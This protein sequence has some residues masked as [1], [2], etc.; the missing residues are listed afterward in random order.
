MTPEWLRMSAGDLGRG[1]ERGEIDPVRLTMAHLDALEAHPLTPRVFSRLTPDRAL[2]EA[3]AASNRAKAGCRRGPLDGIPVSWKDLFDT[4]A[5]ATEA[6]S[7]LLAGRVPERD[8]AVLRNAAA[9]GIVCLGKTHMSELAFS[10]LGY[11][12]VTATPPSVNDAE[13]VAGGSSSGAAAS[14]AFGLSVCGIGSDTGG[15]VRIPSAWNDLVG[16]KTTVGRLPLEGVVPLCPG[17]D[18]VG[19]LCRSVEDAALMLAALEGTV[20]PDLAGASLRGVRLMALETVAMSDLRPE[21]RTGFDLAVALLRDAGATVRPVEV[22]AVAEAMEL[23]SILFTS[24]AYGI[25]KDD[26]EAAPERMFSEIL[27]RFRIGRE[28]SAADYVAGWRSLHRIRREWRE[29]TVGFDAV[30]LPTVPNL[31]P[32]VARLAVD[33]AYFA[34]ENL[35]ALRNTR[36]G[37]LMGTPALTLPTGVRSTGLMLMVSPMQEERLLRIGA[38]AEAALAK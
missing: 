16:L 1:I 9:A 18:T 15:S 14:V 5:I 10:G 7:R 20:V 17:F 13:A 29:A 3:K 26:I 36:I 28:H 34:A 35:L 12:P 33:G 27:A 8:A 25:W 2:S 6:G 21:P 23:A 37:N 30:I 4:S 38:A 32:K 24:E 19:P 11:N 22:P 31:P